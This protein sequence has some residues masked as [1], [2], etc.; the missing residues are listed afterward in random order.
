M[1]SPGRF[2]IESGQST[3]Y[4]AQSTINDDNSLRPSVLANNENTAETNAFY[5]SWYT[6]SYSKRLFERPFLLVLQPQLVYCI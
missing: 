6:L 4:R 3:E 5:L 1:K 2:N